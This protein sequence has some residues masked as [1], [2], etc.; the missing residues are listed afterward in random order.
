MSYV[1]SSNTLILLAR[2]PFQIYYFNE[3]AL[4]VHSHEDSTDVSDHYRDENVLRNGRVLAE[5]ILHEGNLGIVCTMR[6]PCTA[7]RIPVIHF[8][9]EGRG[10]KGR[11][12]MLAGA[13]GKR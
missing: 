5:E 3:N 12:R 9:P 10:D 8:S 7:I 6:L 1:V 2:F 13:T 11:E 4:F